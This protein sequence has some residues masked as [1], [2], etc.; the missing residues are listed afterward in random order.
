ML[1]E[2]HSVII[3]YQ[4][5]KNGKPASKLMGEF[6]DYDGG[7]TTIGTSPFNSLLMSNDFATTFTFIP[8]G[9]MKPMLRLCG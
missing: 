9:P 7:Y 2:H 8:R 6:S 3:D 4:K 5:L 1:R